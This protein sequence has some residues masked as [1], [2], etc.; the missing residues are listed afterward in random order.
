MSDPV[1][2]RYKDALQRG[3]VA[4]VKGR[5]QEAVEHYQEAGRLA[6]GRPLPFVRMG[7]VLL[8]MEQPKE[9]LTAFDEALQRAPSDIAALQGKA[10]ALAATGRLDEARVVG[11][12]ALELAAM[13]QAGRGGYRQADARLAEIEQHMTNG[14]AARRAGDLGIAAVAYL[15]AANGYAALNDHEA[16]LDAC[17]HGLE[18]QPG[19]IDIH[20][21]MTMLYLR[22]GWTELGVQRAMLIEHRLGIDDD[23]LR[24]NAL[25]ALARDFRDLAPEL[26]RLASARS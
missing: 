8:K 23:P 14:A 13:E 6:P 5:P 22:H 18:A 3:H 2:T 21:V 15:T 10:S 7:Q 1:S 16:A 17:L 12:R 19:N 4:V 26:E 20:F 11:S 25:G 9:A 24:R